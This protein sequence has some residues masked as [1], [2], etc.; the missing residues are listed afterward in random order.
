MNRP[1]R[2]RTQRDKR[3]W[4]EQMRS[5]RF[6]NF[7]S[8]WGDQRRIAR[9]MI[10]AHSMIAVKAATVAIC[11]YDPNL[12]PEPFGSGINVHPDGLVLTCKH[13]VE[14]TVPGGLL[15]SESGPQSGELEHERLVAVFALND[16]K[17]LVLGIFQPELMHGFHDHDLAVL[18][19]SLTPL[20]SS[21]A[22]LRRLPFVQVGDSDLP[23]EGERTFTCGFPLGIALQPGAPTGGIF[24]TGILAAVRP[25]P[26]VKPRLQFYID[27]TVNP[28]NSGGPLY[29]EETDTLVGIVNARI[30]PAGIPSGIG[31]AVPVNLAKPLLERALALS[32][33]DVER[34]RAGEWPLTSKDD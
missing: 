20:P 7:L 12:G 28:G 17:G 10:A 13:V 4:A 32:V 5:P 33:A 30:E 3:V 6:I 18:R 19:L 29:S 11:R 15:R 23:F 8:R 21:T 22:D 25:H 31:C 34:M 24:R 14:A 26:L 2:G 27:M 16:E 1:C 9:R